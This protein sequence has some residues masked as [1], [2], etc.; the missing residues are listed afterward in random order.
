MTDLSDDIESIVLDVNS[1]AIALTDNHP[2]H[3]HIRPIVERGVEGEFDL[4]LFDYLPFRAQ[5][6]MEKMFQVPNLEARNSIQHFLRSPV[7]V[8][9]ASRKTLLEAY[10]ISAE[11]NHDVY[12]C[13]FISLARN[14]EA[15]A[16]LTTDTDFEQL[17]E[18]EDFSYLNPVPGPLLAR[19]EKVPG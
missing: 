16:I 18:E 4:L 17:C 7:L 9:S 1:L 11:K 19:F 8:I 12:D 15:D 6:V 2:G 5:Y 10:Q 3:D 13:F 14:E